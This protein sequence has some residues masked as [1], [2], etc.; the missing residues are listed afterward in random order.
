MWKT[1]RERREAY[2]CLL[3][4]AQTRSLQMPAGTVSNSAPLL[5]FIFGDAQIHTCLFFYTS[6]NQKAILSE[7]TLLYFTLVL[8]GQI[9]KDR[10]MDSHLHRPTCRVSIINWFQWSPQ[11]IFHASQFFR[12][13]IRRLISKQLPY[14]SLLICRSFLY[15]CQSVRSQKRWCWL[16]LLCSRHT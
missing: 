1:V 6:L 11:L 16:L 5:C 12:R 8:T 14:G 4:L 13:C 15:V 10:P 9:T 7:L 2:T 3:G